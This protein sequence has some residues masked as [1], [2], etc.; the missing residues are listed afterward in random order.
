MLL[1]VVDSFNGK[2][3]TETYTWWCRLVH[4]FGNAGYTL[5]VVALCLASIDRYHATSRNARLRQ[6]SSMKVATFSVSI[7]TLISLLLSIPDLLYW[8]IDNSF[9]EPKCVNVSTIYSTY[10][11]YFLGLVVY[12]FG[13]LILLIIVGVLT[14]C[15]LKNVQHASHP[16]RTA[17]ISVGATAHTASM[18][19]RIPNNNHSIIQQNDTQQAINI[20]KQRIDTQFS[21]M[22]ILEILCYTF[23]T[24]PQCIQFIYSQATVNYLKSDMTQAI[25][26]LFA[27]LIYVIACTPY[28][29]SFYIYYFSSST[30]R[31]NIKKILCKKR[32]IW[33]ARN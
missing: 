19:T 24:I 3:G 13:T 14:Y 18:I 17:V 10:N 25:E 15:N 20:S 7:V 2:N 32:Q 5:L 33:P 8:Y 9:G 28:C 26:G 30:Y 6:R 21:V 11:M 31:Q 1:N 22:L 4:Y 23:A 27:S 29:T 12:S 16:N